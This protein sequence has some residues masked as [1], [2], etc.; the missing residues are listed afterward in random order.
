MDEE[1]RVQLCRYFDVARLDVFG[2]IARDEARSESHIDLF[3]EL[4]L[5]WEIGDCSEELAELFGRPV[6]LVSWRSPHP[7]PHDDIH[8][9]CGAGL[10]KAPR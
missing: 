8:R 2:S 5:G 6:E 7:V 9:G 10:C 1:H 4:S 3:Y